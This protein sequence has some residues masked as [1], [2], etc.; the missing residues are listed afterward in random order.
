MGGAV[1]ERSVQRLV[2]D[3][4]LP[5]DDA[6]PAPISAV[7]RPARVPLQRMEVVGLSAI[8]GNGAGLVDASFTIDRGSFT[9]LTGPIGSGKSTL[10]RALLGLAW[11]AE[12]S[13]T[14]TWNGEPIADRGEFFVPPNAAFLSQVPQLVSDSVADN[15][16]LGPV[17]AD[18]LRLGARPRCDR[19]RHRRTPR[20]RRHVD[21]PS[22]PPALGRSAPAAGD[23]SSPGARA[24]TRGARRPVERARR[25]DRTAALAEPVRRRA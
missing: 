17:D 22:R 10:L 15:V 23:G 13:G 25:R 20:R 21:R 1:A 16:S 14:V 7:V 8:Y 3:R 11:Q 5:I 2:R 12:V 6:T 19:R 9:V 4:D 18:A 24:R